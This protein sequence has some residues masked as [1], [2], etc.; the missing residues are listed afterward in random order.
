MTKVA[1]A[2]TL[3]Y[4]K[5]AN[6]YDTDE[7]ST[8]F[9]D[10]LYFSN[11][12]KMR[13]FQKAIEIGCGTGRNTVKLLQ[14]NNEILALDISNGMLEIAKSKISD[15]RVVFSNSDILN[16]ELPNHFDF[17]IVS[18]VFEHIEDL[19]MA[20]AQIHKSIKSGGSLYLSEIH[21]ERM[22]NGSGARFI[23]EN[24]NE[25]RAQSFSHSED[26]FENAAKSAGF[27][28]AQKITCYGT[29]GLKKINPKWEKYYGKPM[30]LIY[31]FVKNGD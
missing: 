17:A 3:F 9:V 16:V 8:V 6:N 15:P 10:E 18:L 31:D 25:I 22:Q 23:D 5:W 19:P 28:I 30:L 4:N 11:L 13:H 1:A 7:N 2:N 21:P 29:Q 24:Q 26:D 27:E 14:S 20:F 12:W